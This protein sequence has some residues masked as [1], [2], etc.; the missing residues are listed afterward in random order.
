[1]LLLGTWGTKRNNMKTLRF[2]G[3]CLLA[4]LLCVNFSA[5]GGEDTPEPENPGNNP[6]NPTVGPGNGVSSNEKRLV[7]MEYISDSGN[8]TFSFKYDEQGRVITEIEE[9]DAS[10]GFSIDI[11]RLTW[12][13]NTLT[14]S[15]DDDY[16][17]DDIIIYTLKNGRIV[18][19]RYANENKANTQYEYDNDGRLVKIVSDNSTEV[20]TWINDKISKISREYNYSYGGN[21][22]IEIIYSNQTCKGFFPEFGSLVTDNIFNMA[23]PELFGIRSSYLPTT[24]IEKD[25]DGRVWKHK[26]NYSL[27]EE[28]YIIIYQDETTYT[29]NNSTTSSYLLKN[30]ILTWE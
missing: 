16:D 23:Q 13:G 6:S 29:H 3:V 15:E 7:K 17:N 12:K 18:S 1:M 30:Y 4:S 25:S 20:Y 22:N 14:Y 27:D 21:A 19:E 24:I 11:N 26:Y 10:Y 5:C 2:F 28:G 8:K 9:E